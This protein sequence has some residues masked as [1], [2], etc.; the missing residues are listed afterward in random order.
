MIWKGQ[1]HVEDEGVLVCRWHHYRYYQNAAMRKTGKV[2]TIGHLRYE[3]AD[4]DSRI[5]NEARLN[6]WRGSKIRGGFWLLDRAS[7]SPITF[8]NDIAVVDVDSDGDGDRDGVAAVEQMKG[9]K[10]TAAD[11]FCGAAKLG[12][13]GSRRSAA[14]VLPS[15]RSY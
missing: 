6:A 4:I 15:D 7:S 2:W 14:A 10:Y 8:D 3:N 12:P 13:R 9:Q 11:I 5:G 1:K